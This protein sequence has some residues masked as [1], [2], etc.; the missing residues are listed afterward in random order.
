MKSAQNV[1]KFLA[2]QYGETALQVRRPV[3][4]LRQTQSCWTN[5]IVFLCF[6]LW[7][8]AT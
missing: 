6:L 4:P 3:V 1:E 5:F 7:V 2:E 8:K